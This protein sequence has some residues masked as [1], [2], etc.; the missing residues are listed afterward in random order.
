M[1][2]TIETNSIQKKSLP[3]TLKVLCIL[4]FIGIGLF[5]FVSGIY[6][7]ATI[8][9]KVIEMEAQIQKVEDSGNSMAISILQDAQ[10]AVICAQQNKTSAL[11]VSL[12]SGLLCLAGVLMMWNLKKNGFF[13]YT[14]GELSPIIY[15]FLVI[16]VGKGTFGILTSA[17]TIIIPLVFVILYSVQ[18]KHMD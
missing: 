1:E 6:N 10:N 5:N 9:K 16:G 4:S 8:D 17:F 3:E 18:L 12:I 11:I 7:Y 14:I 13:L 15:T 2:S